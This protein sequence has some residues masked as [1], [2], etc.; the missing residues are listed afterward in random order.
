MTS[1]NDI[2]SY[3]VKVVVAAQ[4]AV[5]CGYAKFLN[6]WKENVPRT[7]RG[8]VRGVWTSGLNQ[9]SLFG[10]SLRGFH[11][12]N[13]RCRLKYLKKT[14][15]VLEALKENKEDRC[16]GGMGFCGLWISFIKT[17]SMTET[18]SSVEL[19]WGRAV[20]RSE[21]WFLFHFIHHRLLSWRPILCTPLCGNNLVTHDYGW[22]CLSLLDCCVLAIV[23]GFCPWVGTH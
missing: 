15:R 17:I 2:W 1:W 9:D 11:M 13:Y 16:E 21:N 10:G 7:L 19:T 23:T 20:D 22:L 18:Y 14:P 6:H 12:R 4:L 3:N 5:G 8:I